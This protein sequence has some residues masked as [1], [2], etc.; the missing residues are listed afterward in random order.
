MDSLRDA[1]TRLDDPAM[2]FVAPE[3]RIVICSATTRRPRRPFSLLDPRKRERREQGEAMVG[4]AETASHISTVVIAESASRSSRRRRANDFRWL[5]ATRTFVSSS[6]SAQARRDSLSR[7][8]QSHHRP[9]GHRPATPHVE[10]LVMG[11]GAAPR[12]KVRA[13]RG[14]TDFIFLIFLMFPHVK[15]GHEIWRSSRSA[16]T[17]SPAQCGANRWQLIFLKTPIRS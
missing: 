11:N 13:D 12:H 3:T 10:K 8:L 6:R 14:I 2:R 15:S 16:T 9:I 5:D 4:R 1:A 17:H 7:A